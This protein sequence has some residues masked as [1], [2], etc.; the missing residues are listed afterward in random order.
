VVPPASNRRVRSQNVISAVALRLSLLGSSL[1]DRQSA[2]QKQGGP[3]P[4]CSALRRLSSSEAYESSS[5][6][7]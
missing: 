2:L 6:R 4:P 1:S 3:R 5:W 7:A